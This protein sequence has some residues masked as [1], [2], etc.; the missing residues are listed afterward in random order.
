MV[1]WLRSRDQCVGN[2]NICRVIFENFETDRAKIANLCFG[3]AI[4]GV[5]PKFNKGIISELHIVELP[6][7]HKLFI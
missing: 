4:L 1:W 5:F 2:Y 6:S 7:P 3:R